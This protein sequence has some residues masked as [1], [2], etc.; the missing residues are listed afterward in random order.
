MSRRLSSFHPFPA[1]MAPELALEAISRV[2]E[3]GLVLDPMAG[4]GTVLRQAS[5]L[6]RRAMGLDLDPLAVLM[7]TVATTKVDDEALASF[8]DE[9]TRKARVLA[10]GDYRPSWITDDLETTTFVDYWFGPAQ[11]R[12][13]AGIA[14][15]LEA[16]CTSEQ[17]IF[18]KPLADVLRLAL[19]RIIVT[20]DSGAS[21][22]RDVSHSR[23]HRVK[24]DSSYDV[25]SS[26]E[27]SVRRLRVSLQA[28]TLKGEVA[29]STGDARQVSSLCKEPID[30]I[31]TS[32]PYLNAI[33]Y[34][35]GHRLALVWLGYTVG[36]LRAI[37]AKS[38]GAERGV[39]R[40]LLTHEQVR[41]L[42]A[43]VGQHSLPNREY[44]L[45][46]RFA[47]DIS[48]LMRE[49][50]KVLRPEGFAVLVVG[51]SLIRGELVNNTA[52]FVQAGL[53]AGFTLLR[54]V[55]RELP[56]SSRYLPVR[57]DSQGKLARR[58]RTESV[59]TLSA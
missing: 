24:I 9:T 36:E 14:L 23:P 44:S 3:D 43:I 32:P 10:S 28:S 45:I 17:A 52:G 18:I 46:G 7:S 37:R 1:R 12:D 58:M 59:I 49:F 15:A 51:N 48:D 4:S 55:E 35:R 22:A 40:R 27:S 21:L 19:S 56:D 38:V 13:L 53:E 31:V 42:D 25:F 54:L 57:G 30:A 41:V 8:A 5:Q 50:K 34:I 2:D 16:A 47:M 20:K 11:Q 33:D 26:F 39:A 29:V 6:G